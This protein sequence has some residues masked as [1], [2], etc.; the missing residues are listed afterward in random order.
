[1]VAIGARHRAIDQFQ[2]MAN[3]TMLSDGVGGRRTDSVSRLPDDSA[4]L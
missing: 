2:I 4:M 3:N 1:M